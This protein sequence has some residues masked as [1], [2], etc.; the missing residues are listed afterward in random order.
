MTRRTAQAV[1]S[2]T[3]HCAVCRS[4]A[5]HHFAIGKIFWILLRSVNGDADSDA[6]Y[7]VSRVHTCCVHEEYAGHAQGERGVLFTVENIRLLSVLVKISCRLASERSTSAARAQH[8]RST[9]DKEREVTALERQG[10]LHQEQPLD[11]G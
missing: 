2:L 7:C 6:L 3:V 1:P 9:S 5:G 10:R 11:G 8:E 4:Q